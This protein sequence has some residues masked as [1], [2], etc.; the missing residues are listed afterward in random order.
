M[1]YQPT[2]GDNELLI[3][4]HIFNFNE[5]IYRKRI[6]IE[7]VDGVRDEQKFDGPGALVEQI[8]KDVER[9]NIILSKN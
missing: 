7:F 5:D 9:V 2:F 6:K 8:K 1:G 3:E 4:T